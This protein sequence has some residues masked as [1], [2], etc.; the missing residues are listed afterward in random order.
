MISNIV[1]SLIVVLL[2]SNA[3]LFIDKKGKNREGRSLDKDFFI[4]KINPVSSMLVIVMNSF[5]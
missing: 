2:E 1:V 4:R 3:L 5:Y